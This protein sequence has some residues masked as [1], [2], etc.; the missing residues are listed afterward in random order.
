M[1]FNFSLSPIF[2]FQ[3]KNSLRDIIFVNF[4]FF[5]CVWGGGGRVGG[6]SNFSDVSASIDSL[7][8]VLSE[9]YNVMDPYY[10]G[11]F[12]VVLC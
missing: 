10:E 8:I 11:Y 7:V 12:V 9:R 4:N 1:L 6:L 2:K 3:W 5:V